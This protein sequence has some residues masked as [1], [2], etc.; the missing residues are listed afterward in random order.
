MGTSL[1]LALTIFPMMVMSTIS[2]KFIAS[3]TKDGLR[4]AIIAALE[5]ILV[6]LL[7]YLFVDWGWVKDMILRTPELILLPMLGN[8]ALGKFTGLRLSEYMKFKSLLGDD[9]Q[10]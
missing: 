6:A 7:A 5:T 1:N 10:E 2:E 8:V 4:N 3:Q 9:I